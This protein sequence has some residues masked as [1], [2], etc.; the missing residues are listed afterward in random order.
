MA[1]TV[2]S[3]GVRAAIV[4]HTMFGEV[5]SFV[6]RVFSALGYRVMFTRLRPE[7]GRPERIAKRDVFEH[8][9]FDIFVCDLSFGSLDSFAGLEIVQGIKKKYPDIL[10]LGTSSKHVDYAQTANRLPSFDIFL[11]KVNFD[12]PGYTEYVAE[13]VGALFH[14]NVC[15]EID[16]VESVLGETFEKGNA[17]VELERMLRSITFTSH[18]A[19]QEEGV[20]RRVVLKPLDGGLSSSTVFQ[21][22]AYSGTGLECVNAVLKVGR[23]AEKWGACGREVENYLSFVKW[24]LPFMWRPELLG[25]SETRNWVGVCYS[26]MYDSGKPFRRLKDGMVCGDNEGIASVARTIFDPKRQRWY[27]Q[28]NVRRGASRLSAYYNEKFALGEGNLEERF[29]EGI[30]KLGGRVENNGVLINGWRFA[31]PDDVLRGQGAGEFSTCI[32]HGDLH[33]GNILIAD[34]GRLAFI[35]FSETGRG[36][37]FEDFVSFEVD[38]RMRYPGD[39]GFAEYFD[40]ESRELTERASPLMY[41]EAIRLVRRLALE[42]FVDEPFSNYLFGLGVFCYRRLR[43]RGGLTDVQLKRIF[44]CLLAVLKTMGHGAR[45]ADGG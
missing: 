45:I 31:L 3:G 10:V 36:H 35:D 30:E 37:V 12:S 40:G 42:N 17:R 16:L 8:S 18:G 4:E 39:M 22:W 26:F 24:Q 1:V 13:Q 21:M 9:V 2:D 15:V 7:G 20:V 44:G 34:G 19:A 14:K 28:K 38:V 11:Y 41:G 43:T 29:K 33:G 6:S 23:K 5:E 32:R 27:H 25:W